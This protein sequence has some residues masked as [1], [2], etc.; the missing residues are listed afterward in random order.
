[1][2]KSK[3]TKLTGLITKLTVAANKAVKK[4]ENSN[5]TQK[6]YVGTGVKVPFNLNHFDQNLRTAKL[7]K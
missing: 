3:S 2:D 5:R 7:L 4:T 6:H 1:M